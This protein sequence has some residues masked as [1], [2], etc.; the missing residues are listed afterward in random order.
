[1]NKESTQRR[2]FL[3]KK[4]SKVD[5]VEQQVVQDQPKVEVVEVKTQVAEVKA[6]TSYIE[7]LSR[8]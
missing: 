6:R 3:I 8:L 1:M 5:A 7:N 2:V 4:D